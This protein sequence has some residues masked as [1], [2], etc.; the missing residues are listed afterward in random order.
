MA[1]DHSGRHYMGY[2]FRLAARDIL[3]APS[4]IKIAHTTAFVEHWLNGPLWA[5]L[6][7]YFCSFVIN[8]GHYLQTIMLL[9]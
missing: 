3:Y 5:A 6:F 2:C 1:K 9:Y 8:D 4:H 7:C